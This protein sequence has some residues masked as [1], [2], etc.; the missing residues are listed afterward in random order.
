MH[1]RKCG[2]RPI[3]CGA[4]L[5]TLGTGMVF[6]EVLKPFS[7]PWWAGEGGLGVAPS[8]WRGALHVTGV[9]LLPRPTPPDPA[10][11]SSPRQSRVLRYHF[12]SAKLVNR[13]GYPLHHV[14]S[15]DQTPPKGKGFALVEDA[16]RRLAFTTN[17]AGGVCWLPKVSMAGAKCW[18]LCAGPACPRPVSD[19]WRCRAT[20]S[21][22]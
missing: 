7:G 4:T 17:A 8:T 5:A 9:T 2:L 6:L 12:A 20:V 1:F 18:P 21:A 13:N 14:V 15:L 11:R 22:C 10:S 16:V 3:E 19:L